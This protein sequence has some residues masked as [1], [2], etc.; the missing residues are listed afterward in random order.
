MSFY[1]VTTIG[2]VIQQYDQ[3]AR[4]KWRGGWLGKAITGSK[5]LSHY[6]AVP[7]GLTSNECN[8]IKSKL[9]SV[10]DQTVATAIQRLSG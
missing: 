6:E 8:L 1:K 4:Y 2:N 9:M 7:T 3:I 5:K 10:N